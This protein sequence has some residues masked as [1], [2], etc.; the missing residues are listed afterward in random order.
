M[1]ITVKRYKNFFK[2]EWDEFV[3]K[4]DNGTIFHYRDFLTYH[5]GRNFIDHSLLFYKNNNLIAIFSATENKLNDKLI[6]H[7]HPG[8]SYGGFVL[9]QY[10]FELIEEII[11]CFEK[12][13]KLTL[14][15]EV[16]LIP[17]PSIYGKIFDE[18]IEYALKWNNFSTEE[19]YISS[20]IELEGD[21][22]SKIHKRKKRYLNKPLDIHF[23]LEW[24]NDFEGFHPI[25]LENKHKHKV[26]P[27]HSL[28][29]LKLLSKKFPG[30]LKLLMLY[31]NNKPIGGTLNFIANDRV[32]IIFYNMIN[33]KYAGKQPATHL[34][35]E[36]IHWAKS[37]NFKWLDFGVSQ[38]PLHKNP[39]TPHKTLIQFKEKFGATGF[40]RRVYRKKIN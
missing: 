34:I 31:K 39:L 19:I 6:L 21:P 29:E 25:L 35:A 1:I 38:L 26:K 12:Y 24:N 27:T 32:V 3:N 18:T 28:E 4:S 9:K 8:A 36:T 20:A 15:N 30:K 11:T 40:L 33:Y 5:I 10:T 16:L 37:E 17:P 22:I 2:Q 23:K 13:L 7:S 14:F